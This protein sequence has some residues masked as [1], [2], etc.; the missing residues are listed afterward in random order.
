MKPRYLVPIVFLL[1]CIQTVLASDTDNASNTNAKNSYN[2]ETLLSFYAQKN[3]TTIIVDP[4][5]NASIKL[6]G[7]RADEINEADL[8]SILHVHG[9]AMVKSGE[10]FVVKPIAIAKQSAIDVYKSAGSTPHAS[11]QVTTV[12]QLNHIHGAQLIPVLRPL[13]PKEGHFA[14]HSPSNTLVLTDTYENTQRIID[15]IT[16]M[17]KASTTI[18]KD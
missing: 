9:L 15:I 14:A 2:I 4:R 12:I 11:Q 7:K 17:D 13:I 10:L 8:Q 6:Y 3:N 18:K 16:E 1:M 5:T